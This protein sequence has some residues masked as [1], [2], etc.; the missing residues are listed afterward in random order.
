[1]PLASAGVWYVR[2]GGHIHNGGGVNPANAS[3]STNYA[4]QDTAQITVTNAACAG[5]TT[6]TSATANFDSTHHGNYIGLVTGGGS[7]I[8][9]YE[10]VSVTNSTTVVL[11]KAGPTDTGMTLR[12]GGAHVLSN[13][14]LPCVQIGGA[15]GVAVGGN[16]IHVNGASGYALSSTGITLSSDGS[17]TNPITII[18]HSTVI[19]DG[20]RPVITRAASTI[21]L[22]WVSTGDN[23]ILKN[24]EFDGNGAGNDCILIDGSGCYFENVVARRGVDAL[25]LNGFNNYFTDCWFKDGQSSSDVS[26][27]ISG[28]AGN[29]FNRCAISDSLGVGILSVSGGPNT[30]RHCFIY[31]HA[32]DGV[33]Q[34]STGQYGL[35]FEQCAIWDNGR[36][37][38]RFSSTVAVTGALH[39]VFVRGTIFGKN[40]G[41][42]INYTVSDIS[43]L[44]GTIQWVASHFDCNAFYTTGLGKMNQLPANSG[45]LTLTA[46]PFAS[47]TSF[48]LTGAG[49]Q[50]IVENVCSTTL[51]DGNTVSLLSG[52]SQVTAGA[53]VS[54]ALNLWREWAG[55][56]FN[57]TVIPDS[58][59]QDFYFDPSCNELNRRV[60]YHLSTTTITLAAGTQSYSLP[61]DFVSVVY[62]SHAGKNLQK[63]SE[64]DWQ[65]EGTAYR[66]QSGSPADYAI[67][68]STLILRPIP[69]AA[70]VAD[71][72]V[73]SIRYV[74]K[75]A[76]TGV[77]G[78]AQL[79]TQ[80]I[81]VVVRHAVFL[82]WAANGYGTD[83][84]G[85]AKFFYDL[86]EQGATRIAGQYAGRLVEP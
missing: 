3:Y 84:S 28:G 55:G 26:V 70:T 54:G 48:V 32:T 76:A 30:F 15:D 61:E 43:A 62:V 6:L 40:L 72:S 83:V 8:N 41:Y 38:I 81:E 24:L 80:D 77:S 79:S 19:G 37:G 86:F 34:E 5:T 46:S 68:G 69:T 66:E 59:I 13:V 31:N 27:R 78:F 65:R 2:P 4:N 21:N 11:D 42:D 52:A 44:T 49:G 63:K 73:V 18:G 33:Q 35:V 16:V 22:L 7:F 85:R 50:Q 57:T 51:P 29:V 64:E 1:M 75:P 53:G 10:V 45:D 25:Q 9:Y 14:G 67:Q 23:W 17:N 74:S 56:E 36:D 60:G 58:T 71:A 82:W 12:L 39:N 20:G 47:D